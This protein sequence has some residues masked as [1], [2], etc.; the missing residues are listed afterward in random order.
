MEKALEDDTYVH[1]DNFT[2]ETF[3]P[4]V[5]VLEVCKMSDDRNHNLDSEFESVNDSAIWR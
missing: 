5:L 3:V 1:R 4:E 2:R